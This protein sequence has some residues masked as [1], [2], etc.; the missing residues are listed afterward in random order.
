MHEA[1][2]PPS[3]GDQDGDIGII[4]LNSRRSCWPLSKITAPLLQQLNEQV[5]KN[6]CAKVDLRNVEKFEIKFVL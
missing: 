4:A 2:P 3:E 1:L 6:I 5:E